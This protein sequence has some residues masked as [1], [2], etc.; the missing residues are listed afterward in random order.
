MLHIID[1]MH[2]TSGTST[3]QP[4]SAPAVSHETE[5]AYTLIEGRADAGYVIFCDH[6]SNALPADYGSLGLAASELERHIG[7]DIGAAG[8]VRRL[9]GLRGAPAI[10]SR[11]SR[12]LID[13]N[14]GT[15]DPTL[16]M[17]LSDGAIVPGNRHLDAAERAKRIARYYEPYHRAA[18]AMIDRCVEAGAP[19]AIIS[20][21]SFTPFWKGVPRPWHAAILWDK[22]PRLAL[23]LLTG[24]RAEP[25]LVVGE[26][27][28]YTGRLK[29]DTMWRHGTSR[30]LAH[31]IVEIR[32]DLIATEAG[33]AEWAA[34]LDRILRDLASRRD[35]VPVLRQ[36]T[37]HGSHTD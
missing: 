3:R 8:V 31:A 1:T 33:E 9:A 32:Q 25:G 6:A 23:A 26:N 19:P 5:D 16:I 13:L 18:G 34:L 24:L 28:P 14:R 11:Y 36:I 22:D 30:G 29:G 12:L 17:R 4:E 27:E 21:H 35:L 10:L 2:D 37:F 15:D 20:I 7:Y